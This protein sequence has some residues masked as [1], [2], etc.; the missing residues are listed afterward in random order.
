MKKV[1]LICNAGM[2]TGILAKKIEAAS[3]GTLDVKAY[4]EAEYE[5]YLEGIDLV[6]IGP[7][8]VFLMD[9]IKKNVSVP[10]DSIAPVKYGLM[11][12]QGV[13]QDIIKLL[14]E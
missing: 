14:G 13:Y 6:L 9:N 1:M 11:D 8:I 10:V 12:G 5:D 2:S 3:N 7:Q 4:S